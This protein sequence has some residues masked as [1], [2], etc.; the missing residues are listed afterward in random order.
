VKSNHFSDLLSL[1]KKN[2]AKMEVSKMMSRKTKNKILSIP[3][4][5]LNQTRS[6]RS[7]KIMESS[8]P[9]QSKYKKSA[10]I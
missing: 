3:P 7:I 5:N 6:N 10:T 9:S 2:K 4:L 8:Q 1:K